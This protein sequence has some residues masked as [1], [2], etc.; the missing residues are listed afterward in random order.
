MP[1]ASKAKRRR[2]KTPGEG[3]AANGSRSPAK[4]KKKG[5]KAADVKDEDTGNQENG[6]NEQDQNDVKPKTRRKRQVKNGASTKPETVTSQSKGRTKSLDNRSKSFT[7]RKPIADDI[8]FYELDCRDTNHY[9]YIKEHYNAKESGIYQIG[10]VLGSGMIG[11]ACLCQ[12]EENNIL[13]C[14]KL[15]S[16]EKIK[17][18]NLFKNIKDEVQ[19]MYD[20]IGVHGVCQIEDI[21]INE[22]K[23]VTI[24]M[25]F[26]AL[27]DLWNF[28]K[29]Q[30]GRHLTEYDARKVFCQL[31]HTF[32]GIHSRQIMH[33]DIKPENILVKND[34]LDVC[35]SD[36]GL[37]T[38][39]GPWPQYER[40]RT[41][42]AGT[43]CYYSYEI[44]KKIPYDERV[45]VWCL[46]ILLFEMLFGA[47][48]F[49]HAPNDP[50]DYSASISSLAY[51]FPSKSRVSQE[52]RD[53]IQKI[54]VPQETRITLQQIQEH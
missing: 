47:L 38:R 3:K 4:R 34:Q 17:E 37:A 11:V 27:T 10:K 24:V 42:Q 14:L 13:S 49:S 8:D 32:I 16:I 12:N 26:Y 54:L 52:A 15:M 22:H 2:A 9:G 5:G 51:K 45:D 7:K 6:L 23:D 48:P 30:P 31:V 29:V 20:L 43:P 53:L 36:F 28:M 33:R 44:I 35:L 39:V 46:G 1:T 50:R 40:T 41:G 21:I 25:P 19:I 18:K